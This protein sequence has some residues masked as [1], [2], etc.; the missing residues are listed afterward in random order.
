MTGEMKWWTISLV[1]E[2][3]AE[4]EVEAASFSE[5]SAQAKGL[6]IDRC[7]WGDVYKFPFMVSLRRECTR[8]K[9]GPTSGL[10]K[11]GAPA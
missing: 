6:F 8:C 4:I 2:V 7:D 10:D 5:A 11:D 9:A 3:G 1:A